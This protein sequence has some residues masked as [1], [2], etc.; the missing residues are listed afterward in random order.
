MH[1]D[2]FG[3]THGSFRAQFAA[4][5]EIT[6]KRTFDTS[7]ER[8]F[9]ALAD[10]Q[11]MARW[12]GG[13]ITVPV[14]GPGGL[15]GTI[16]RMHLGPISMDE[17]IIGAERPYSLSYQI[18]RGIPALKHHLGELKLEPHGPERSDL[19]WRITFELTSPLLSSLILRAMRPTIERGLE[20]LSKQLG[21]G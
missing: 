9:D 16:R 2:S 1:F 15:V 18:I 13:R 3:L 4:V 17:Q 20:R 5:G 19:T 21:R 8:L 11:N 12:M 10:Q 6:I 7:A 14:Q